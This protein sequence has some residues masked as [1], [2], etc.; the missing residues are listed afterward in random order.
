LQVPT[1]RSRC[2]WRL[3]A[4]EGDRVIG[5]IRN[6]DH[7]AEVSRAGAVPVRCDLER[8]SVEEIATAIQGADA[9]VFAADARLGSGAERKLTMDRDGAIKLLRAD[10]RRRRAL[11]HDQRGRRREPAG[12]RRGVRRLSAGEGAGRC[13]AAGERPGVDDPQAGWLDRRWGTRRVRIDS[14]PFSGP[15]S[16][17][18]VASV[19]TRLLTDSRSVGRVQYLSSGAQSIEQALDEVLGS[20]VCY[21]KRRIVTKHRITVLGTGDMGGAIAQ[22]LAERTQHAV[23][24]RGSRPG[25]ASAAALVDRLALREATDA[26]IEQSDIVFVVVPAKAIPEIV[27][28]LNDYGGIVVS[29]SVS[30][31]VGRD[32]HKS[33]AEQLAEALPAA[34]VVNAFSSIWSTVVR[35]PGR[36]GKT[37]A[38]VC[39]RRA[40]CPVLR[41]GRYAPGSEAHHYEGRSADVVCCPGGRLA[42]CDCWYFPARCGC[43]AW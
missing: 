19:L 4:A 41:F 23:T 9:V 2:D 20:P 36:V 27:P 38:F 43:A 29:V 13:G 7:A 6:P 8:A 3:L 42:G 30:A 11:P 10:D 28:T 21:R 26:D 18:D 33:T 35:N 39:S 14:A 5:L 32:G 16:R 25:S 37:S 12:R 17:D 34:R 1:D 40:S 31:T 24:V 22:A 15:V